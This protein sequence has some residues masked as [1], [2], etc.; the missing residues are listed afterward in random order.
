MFSS[1]SLAS[2][3]EYGNVGTDDVEAD[4]VNDFGKYRVH[5]ARHEWRSRMRVSAQVGRSLQ[6]LESRRATWPTMW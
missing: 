5:F 4:L 2:H 1:S 6:I 3:Q